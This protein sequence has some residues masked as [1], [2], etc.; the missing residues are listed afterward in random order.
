MAKILVTGG[1]GYI[2]SHTV[3]ELAKSGYDV[4]IIDDLSN[5]EISVLEALKEIVS[6]ELECNILDLK[7]KSEI[8]NLFEGSR[9]DAAIHFAASKSVGESVQDPLKYYE[10]NILGMVNLLMAMKQNGVDSLVFSSSCTVYGNPDELPVTEKSPLKP[11]ASPYGNTKKICEEI[12]MDATK[13]NG[14]LKAISLRY[15]NPIGA[16][17]SALIGERYIGI[18]NNLLPYL[19]EVAS[20]KREILKVFGGDYNTHDG[21]PIRDYIH[22]VDLA[23]AHVLAVDRLLNQPVDS[24]QFEVFNLGSGNGFS[25]LDIVKSFEKVNNIK[26]K[27]EIVDR[28]PGD[29]E[30]IY[31]DNKL[32]MEILGWEPTL[33]VDEMMTSA[34]N[35]EKRNK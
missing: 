6:E 35:W 31:A 30:K 10:N 18:P 22:V 8:A 24:S 9:F 19:L 17:S 25:V 34:W 13:S 27:Y 20:G 29:V 28:R 23:Q 16:H 7:N 2:G 32:S 33:Q 21:T 14:S 1:L 15:F 26:I 5:S 4:S 3:V 12:I 11:P